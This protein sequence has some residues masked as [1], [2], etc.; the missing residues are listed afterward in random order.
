MA[1][2]D[3][4]YC[5]QARRIVATD[6]FHAGVFNSRNCSGCRQ[7]SPWME[8]MVRENLFATLERA[9]Y[10][11]ELLSQPNEQGAPDE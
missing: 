7:I 9:K 4:R 1:L 2:D 6:E 11:L 8:S 10:H 3:L 5:V